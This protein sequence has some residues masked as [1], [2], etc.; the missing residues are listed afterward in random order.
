MLWWTWRCRL[1][2]SSL[3]LSC[4]SSL[5]ILD[6]NPLSDIAFADIFSHFVRCLSFYCWFP[7]LC[8]IFLVWGSQYKY[9]FSPSVVSDSLRPHGLQH[10][11]LPCPLPTSK[12]CSNSRPPIWWCHPIILSS[13]IPVFSCL[14]SFPSS[15]SFPVS[16]FFT[17][18]NQSI[19]ASASTSVLPMNIQG[20]FPLGLIAL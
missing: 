8:I 15:G 18:G 6:I 16:Q 1:N 7:L 14:Q 9:Q 19:G 2:Q 3:L 5:Y 4:M 10:C 13:V 11:R 20:W 17:S 12:V